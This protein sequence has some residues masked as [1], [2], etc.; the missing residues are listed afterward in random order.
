[1]RKK[2]L[3]TIS[4]ALLGLALTLGGAG[5]SLLEPIQ[6]SPV[7]IVSIE[8][9]SSDGLVDTYTISYSDGTTSTFEVT[10]GS[11]GEKGENGQDGQDGASGKDGEKGQ[12]VTALD[13]YETYKELYGE[14]LTY[15][16]F[17]SKYL[18]V[19]EST[20][21]ETY[22]AIHDCLQSVGKVYCAFTE[23][24]LE[25]TED[26]TD[27]KNALYTG[28]CVLYQ[29]DND[30]TY[31]LTNYHVVFSENATEN[32]ISEEIYCYL[33]GSEGRPT[34]KDTQWEFGAKAVA[35]EYVGG[36]IQYDLA[37]VRAETAAVKAINEKAKPVT[38]AK[39]YYVGQ[40]AITVGNPNGDGLSVTQGIVSVDSEYI[41]LSMDGTK[42]DYR[43]MRIDTALYPGNS[44]GGLFNEDGELIG[45]SNAGSITDQN[46]N[47]AIPVS[48][49]KGVA[50]NIMT[51]YRGGEAVNGV[52]TITLGFDKDIQN[53]KYTYYA[54]KGYGKI[55][56]EICVT[57]VKSGSIAESM[58]L[59][60][61]DIVKAIII[62]GVEHAIERSFD[63]SDYIL[64]LM[65]GVTFS[66]TYERE[67]GEGNTST[68]TVR[69]S[70]L[71]LVNG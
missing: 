47:F 26:T 64:H 39:E 45:I 59:Q 3:M 14:D 25:T 56:E 55:T 8:K 16:E 38:L 32:T 67:G 68:H 42:R 2:V 15:E 41:S 66:F 53:S 46:I 23:W 11:D 4:G 62:D 33:Y 24:N 65:E 60:V 7:S 52:H 28:A 48:I 37:I 50:E 10:N 63:V 36:A 12:D 49:V 35:C 21:K 31:F 51:H 5:C 19:G 61:G 57:E 20:E 54:D 69:S 29:M 44:G 18:S 17:L 13:L 1:M 6:S 43:S 40:T 58:G 71:K 30:Y 27:T 34:K 9:T 70:E 22:T